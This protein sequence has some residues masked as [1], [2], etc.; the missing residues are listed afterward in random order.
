MMRNRHA[1]DVALLLT[2]LGLE[3]QVVV[4][5]VLPRK[6]AAAVFEYLSL[7]AK[8]ALPQG[9]GAGGCRCAAEQHGA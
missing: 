5:R 7:E 4:F 8:E 9:H 3:D 1:S 6:D 2:E